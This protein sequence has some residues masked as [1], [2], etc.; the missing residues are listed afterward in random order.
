MGLV[1][2]GREELLHVEM[3]G[4]ELFE[5][6]EDLEGVSEVEKEVVFF[7]ESRNQFELHYL[8]ELSLDWV[9]ERVLEVGDHEDEELE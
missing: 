8:E 6:K 2:E 3:R 9:R 5:L 4:E 1:A 7:L